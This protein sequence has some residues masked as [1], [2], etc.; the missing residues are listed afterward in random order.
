MNN[1]NGKILTINENGEAS[2]K[3]EPY[4]VIECRTELEFETLQK[5]L[6][7]Y[8]ENVMKEEGEII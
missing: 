1:E 5:A 3:E 2:I 6:K 7:Y 4:A 8:S